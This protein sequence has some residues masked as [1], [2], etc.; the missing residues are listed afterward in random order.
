MP[1]ESNTLV[2]EPDAAQ[3]LKSYNIPYPKHGLAKDPAEAVGIAE[4]IG[5]PVVLKIV[6]PDVIHKSDAGGVLV[7]MQGP[8]NVRHGFG[9]LVNKVQETMPEAQINGVLVC[10][11]C[12]EGLE[13]IIGAIRDPV[14]G[15]TVMVGLGGIFTEV[16][17]DITFRI[18]PLKKI[19][20]QEMIEEMKGS[21][22]LKAMRGQPARDITAFI[23]A[24]LSV[25]RLIIENDDIV[26]L[27]LNPVRLYENGLEAL[28]VR[29]IRA[30]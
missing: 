5:Y 13:T 1:I 25:S 10:R 23:E 3:I 4:M 21:Q 6:S 15:P 11:Q 16:I 27:D 22:L 20:A 8:D 12:K 18:A 14:F 17:K 29:L 24:L 2:P 30:G 26:E 19:D 28:D 9:M 7:G